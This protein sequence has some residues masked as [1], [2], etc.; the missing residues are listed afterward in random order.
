M[1]KE[2]AIE[3]IIFWCTDPKNNDAR[4]DQI[5]HRWQQLMFDIKTE[6][7][8]FRVRGTGRNRI[9]VIAEDGTTVIFN[10]SQ[11]EFDY[12]HDLFRKGFEDVKLEIPKDI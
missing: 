1:N 6:D 11:L 4:L 7:L 3:K 8:L 2:T 12:L 9:L 10:I 5:K